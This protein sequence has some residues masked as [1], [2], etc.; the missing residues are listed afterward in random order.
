MKSAKM[1]G[2][3]R[4]QTYDE[5]INYLHYGQEVVKY[6]NR[7]AKQ[8]RESPY[9]TQLDGEDLDQQHESSKPAKEAIDNATGFGSDREKSGRATYTKWG[10]KK[11]GKSP[12]TACGCRTSI[13]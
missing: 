7:K 10:S 9:M 3:R 6:P 4:K 8:L 11:W 12:T 1:S 13:S 2:L 5:M